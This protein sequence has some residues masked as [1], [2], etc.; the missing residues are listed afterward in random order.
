MD[1]LRALPFD[2]IFWCGFLGAAGVEVVALFNAYRRVRPPKRVRQIPFW[3]LWL[4]VCCLGGWLAAGVFE[5]DHPVL[6]TATG[7]SANLL[8]QKFARDTPG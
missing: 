3:I 5:L 2:R 7:A 4:A 8:I 1:A 6:A